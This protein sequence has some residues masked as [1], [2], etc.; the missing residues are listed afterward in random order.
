M[1]SINTNLIPNITKI[2]SKSGNV[3]SNKK[4]EGKVSE[5]DQL[6]KGQLESKEISENKD[7]QFSKHA[8]QRIED[9]NLNIDN[10]EFLKLRNAIE[11][12]KEKGGKDSLVVTD[13]AAYIIDVNKGKV[14]T[15]IDKNNMAENVFTK[16]DS[17]LFIN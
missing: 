3:S 1:G 12:L 11:Q 10:T 13:K 15:A 8:K 7:I 9:R 2:P 4:V 6:L 17:T 5:F 16:I 14:V